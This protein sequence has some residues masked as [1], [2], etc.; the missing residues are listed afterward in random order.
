MPEPE[1]VPVD[2]G[3]ADAYLANARAQ[4][5]QNEAAE[6]PGIG[7]KV[8]GGIGWTLGLLARPAQTGLHGLLTGN[9]RE[10][11]QAF[12]SILDDTK[13]KD[14]SD[15]RKDVLN[16]RPEADDKTWFG[17]GVGNF[18]T[19]LGVGAL[20]LAGNIATDPLTLVNPLNM[21]KAGAALRSVQEGAQAELLAGGKNILQK[22]AARQG[23]EV[24]EYAAK[25]ESEILAGLKKD[26]D[27]RAVKD[28]L[29][30]PDVAKMYAKAELDAVKYAQE[31]APHLELAA[32]TNAQ[33]GILAKQHGV[34][35]KFVPT[36]EPP[37]GTFEEVQ[38]SFNA[39]KGDLKNS[40][41]EM[42]PK[43][44]GDQINQGYRS[45]IGIGNPLA[46]ATGGYNL[47]LKNPGA[48]LNKVADFKDGVVQTMEA[49]TIGRAVI[50]T[51]L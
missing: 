43:R 45:V 19:K 20:D 3:Y 23:M 17:N 39:Y 37:I 15:I 11:G 29:T 28:G 24:T 10:M 2:T 25:K 13:A 36:W 34:T 16:I 1:D 8:L 32:E 27:A 7:S 31:V 33:L 12:D 21:T 47:G 4:S 46:E 6:G 50:D 48:V 51:I 9:S 5:E 41:N 18:A 30:Q 44:L 35:P 49:T 40:I 22:Q 26:I 14:F 42:M 38:Q